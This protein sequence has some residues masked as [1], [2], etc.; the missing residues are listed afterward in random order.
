MGGCGGANGLKQ[1][2]CRGAGKGVAGFRTIDDLGE[3]T[4]ER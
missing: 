4:L 2:D 3:D 1:L